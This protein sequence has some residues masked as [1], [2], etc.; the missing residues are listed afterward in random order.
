MKAVVLDGSRAGDVAG[1]RIG[2]ATLAVLAAQG[3]QVEAFLLRE[4]KIGNCAGDFFCWVR[5][6]GQCMLDDDN[7]TVAAAIANADLLVCLTPITF[8]GYSSALKRQIDH[9]IQSIS[10]FF[11]QVAGETHHQ[12]RYERYP[13]LLVIGRQERPDPDAAAVCRLATRTEGAR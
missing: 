4:A 11:A 10:P 3:W 2:Q 9:Q 5:T 13:N 6:P 1:E 7:R 8:G 12:R